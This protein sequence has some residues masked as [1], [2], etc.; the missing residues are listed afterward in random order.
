[1]HIEGSIPVN[2]GVSIGGTPMD[3]AA[4]PG[5]QF[6]NITNLDN[7]ESC[8]RVL[9]RSAPSNGGGGTSSGGGS[10]SGGGNSSGGG[11]TK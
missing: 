3:Y 2:Q 4:C 10:S 7:C 1:M 9:P 5:C 6:N 11:A 8:G